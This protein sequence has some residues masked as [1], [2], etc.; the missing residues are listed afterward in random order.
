[1]SE[2]DLGELREYLHRFAADRDWE[3]FHS[4]KNLAMALAAEAGELLEVFQWLTPDESAALTDDQRRAAA[5][6]IADVLQ[7]LV[8]LADVL[9]V[10]LG[11]EVWRKL[12]ENQ[13][14][15]EAGEV[16]GSA[17]KR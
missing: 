16:R 9:G 12:R 10:D 1:M 14:R 15:Y 8:R 11:V 4:P 13:E 17:G 3:Q 2:L 7:Y 6:E 5:D